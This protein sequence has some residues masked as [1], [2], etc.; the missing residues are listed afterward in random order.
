MLTT[1]AVLEKTNSKHEA[2]RTVVQRIHE[3]TIGGAADMARETVQALAALAK[4]QETGLTEALKVAA[5]DILRVLP[6]FAPPVNALHRVIAAVDGDG[7]TRETVLAACDAFLDHQSKVLAATARNAAELVSDGDTVFMYSMSKTVWRALEYA[8]DDGKKFK[9]VVTESRP[10][11]EGLWTVTEMERLGVEV[12]LSIDAC[13][14]DLV[15]RADIVFVG[16]DAIASDGRTLCKVGTYPTA[17][18]ARDAGVPFYILADTL[19]FDLTTLLGLAFRVEGVPPS[20]V[21]GPE[22]ASKFDVV[23]PLFDVTPAR[24]VSGLVTEAGVFNPTAAGPLMAGLPR[25][26]FI[27]TLIPAWARHAL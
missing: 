2:V 24:L 20:Q 16:A 6:S 1:A 22:G 7:A 21:P 25:S 11:N 4:D 5:T 15:P 13:I 14:G 10:A 12:S 27:D 17:L 3:D 8:R 19:K 9:V 23:G 18:V 26:S